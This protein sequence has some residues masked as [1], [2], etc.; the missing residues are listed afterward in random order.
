VINQWIDC[1]C[2]CKLSIDG[3]NRSIEINQSIDGSTRTIAIDQFNDDWN[4]SSAMAI[5]QWWKQLIDCGCDCNCDCS[6]SCGCDWA[7]DDGSNP[8]VDDGNNWWQQLV[9]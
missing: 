1:N 4:W 3:S 8:S 7:I 2:D 6:C 5:N 9:N